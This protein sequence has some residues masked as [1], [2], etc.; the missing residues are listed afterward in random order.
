MVKNRLKPFRDRGPG[1]DF[2]C[3]VFDNYFLWLTETAPDYGSQ[4]ALDG[5]EPW[6]L[7]P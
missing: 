5:Y 2:C 6:S 1:K 7:G 3:F 4:A